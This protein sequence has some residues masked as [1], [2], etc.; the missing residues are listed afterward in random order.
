MGNEIIE[1][2]GLMM[3]EALKYYEKV[4]KSLPK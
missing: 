1:N 2:I 3:I 4:N